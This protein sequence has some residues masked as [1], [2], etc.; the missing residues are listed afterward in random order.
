MAEWTPHILTSAGRKLQA[1]VETGTPLKLTRMKLGSGQET[2]EEADSLLDLVAAETDLP[3]SS[4][5]AD[6]ELCTVT[7]VLLT[8]SLNHGFYCREWGIFAQD[9]DIGEILYAVLIDE[10]P[11]W[12]PSNSP[13]ELTITYCLNIAVA[14]GSII[15]ADVD[16]A[17][18][19]DVDMLHRYTHAMRR[20]TKYKAGDVVTS[21]T[22]PHG[23]VL[24]AQ[25]DGISSDTLVDFSGYSC[26]DTFVDGSLVW[27]V[28]RIVVTTSDDGS[29]EP[30][31]ESSIIVTEITIPTSGW[32]ART[33]DIVD[34]E[35]AMQLDIE[36]DGADETMFPHLALALSSLSV[37]GDAVLC[38]TI[39]S[40]DGYVR[41]WAKRAPTE[42]ITGVLALLSAPHNGGAGAHIFRVPVQKWVEL[43]EAESDYRLQADIAVPHVTA[44]ALPMV[45]FNIASLP[46]A[47][48]AEICPTIQALDGFVR[49]WAKAKPTEDIKGTLTLLYSNG[50]NPARLPT[51]TDSVLGG[52]RIK[53]G[54]GLRIDEEGN[55]SINA[56]TPKEVEEL[57]DR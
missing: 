53:E 7:G 23:L 56:A 17:G 9:P 14:N 30:T 43:E 50:A 41:L 20:N 16:P 47:Q 4:A 15:S 27:I 45:A 36:I 38:P 13:T 46:V 34:S 28:K 35:Y 44:K 18:L 31:G 24:E 2:I 49:L 19:V 12:I 51:A 54:S 57:Y 39:K 21:P 37:A 33:D 11:D 40:C 25:T 1:K 52:V 32:K 3:I 22:L 5:E 29:I 6:G 26:G 48:A 10:K 42:K 8:S 55:L